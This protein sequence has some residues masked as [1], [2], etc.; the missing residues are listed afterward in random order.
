V[1]YFKQLDNL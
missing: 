1:K